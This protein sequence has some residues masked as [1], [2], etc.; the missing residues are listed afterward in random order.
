M[1]SKMKNI[2]TQ[3]S[4]TD[5]Q[6]YQLMIHIQ[7]I[8]MATMVIVIVLSLLSSIM[9]MKKCILLMMR[10]LSTQLTFMTIL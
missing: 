5:T 7:S 4:I 6:S 9:F 2:M 3:N 8:L 10:A 1:M